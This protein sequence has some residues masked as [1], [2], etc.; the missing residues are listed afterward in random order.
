VP[1]RRISCGEVAGDAGVDVVVIV[2]VV[3]VAGGAALAVDVAACGFA[4]IA[5]TERL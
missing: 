1:S 2:A 5:T 4:A 3:V